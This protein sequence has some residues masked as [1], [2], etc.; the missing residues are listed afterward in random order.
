MVRAA[1]LISAIAA[2]AFTA[3]AAPADE[4]R[5]NV[6][7]LGLENILNNLQLKKIVSNNDIVKNVNAKVL[8]RDAIK[9]VVIERTKG[10]PLKGSSA[11]TV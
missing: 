4:V 9:K 1:F 10:Q 3:S 7:G 11:N 5:G 6:I 2:L 8:K